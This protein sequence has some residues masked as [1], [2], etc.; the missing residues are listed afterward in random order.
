MSA[1][2]W[3]A[4]RGY[5]LAPWKSPYWRW[6][7]ETYLGVEAK[8]LDFRAFWRLAWTHR[9]ALLRYL[10]WASRMRTAHGS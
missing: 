3:Q 10:R 9:A 2:L 8:E 6:R 5:R 7:L 1:L 4:S